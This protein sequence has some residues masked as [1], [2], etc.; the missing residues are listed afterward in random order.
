VAKTRGMPVVLTS[1]MESSNGES[2]L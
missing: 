1:G 2:E